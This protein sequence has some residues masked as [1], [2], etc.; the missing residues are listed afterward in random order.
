MALYNLYGELVASQAAPASPASSAAGLAKLH[1]GG[2][3]ID[4]TAQDFEAMF[5][6]QMLQPMF[7]GVGT[8]PTFGGGHGEEMMKTFMLQEYGKIMAKSG[9]LGI[10]AHVKDQMIKAQSIANAP[11][12]GKDVPNAPIQ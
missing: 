4:K 9:H 6:T 12:T 5:M 8:N 2:V 11:T 3:N 10:A 1:N 7:Q